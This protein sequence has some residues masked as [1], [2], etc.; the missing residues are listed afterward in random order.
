MQ[1][2]QAEQTFL[3]FWPHLKILRCFI[4]MK[5]CKGRL[6]AANVMLETEM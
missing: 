1:M 2:V 3:L 6:L 4:Q 5:M